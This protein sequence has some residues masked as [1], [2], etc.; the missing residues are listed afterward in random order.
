MLQESIAFK[1]VSPLV[2]DYMR[3]HSTVSAYKKGTL[4]FRWVSV[5]CVASLS[6]TGLPTPADTAT[7]LGHISCRW[8]GQ[9]HVPT[10]ARCSCPCSEARSRGTAPGFFLVISGMVRI[11]TRRG[12][13]LEQHYQVG[14]G[15]RCDAC[16]MMTSGHVPVCNLSTFAACLRCNWPKFSRLF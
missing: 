8:I 12:D 6:S 11:I 15:A 9:M 14:V 3:A 5:A 1:G 7:M 10:T 2:F 13:T 16:D 4:I